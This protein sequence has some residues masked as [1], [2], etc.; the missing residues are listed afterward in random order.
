MNTLFSI[1]QEFIGLIFFKNVADFLNVDELTF[2]DYIFLFFAKNTFRIIKN[3]SIKYLLDTLLYLDFLKHHRK[4]FSKDFY[5]IQTCSLV[6]F[7]TKSISFFLEFENENKFVFKE[8]LNEPFRKIIEGI[9]LE[10]KI[11]Q[12]NTGLQ[13]WRNQNQNLLTFD[14]LN[15][16]YQEIL[17][18]KLI[19]IE[20]D[21]NLSQVYSANQSKFNIFV[22]RFGCLFPV[23][24]GQ[25]IST[26]NG[27][28]RRKNNKKNKKPIYN[29]FLL[30]LE[31]FF[32][33][34]YCKTRIDILNFYFFKEIYYLKKEDSSFSKFL[35]KY[36]KISTIK[37]KMDFKKFS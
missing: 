25:E 11:K 34:K 26:I 28:P 9:L 36:S 27:N 37:L 4:L 15:Q 5:L 8:K 21:I 23:L 16:S 33:K 13:F 31:R 7:F 24:F 14:I 2:H 1:F 30:R 29:M 12:L 22:K 20:N 3:K 32:L 6:T 18:K 19:R 10:R 17:R 35:S